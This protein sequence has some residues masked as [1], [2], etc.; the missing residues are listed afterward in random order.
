MISIHQQYEI[1]IS[2]EKICFWYI[3]LCN[4]LRY[5]L[6]PPQTSGL[7]KEIKCKL[8]LSHLGSNPCIFKLAGEYL[9]SRLPSMKQNTKEDLQFLAI[10][11]NQ[12]KDK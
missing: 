6:L 3:F 12:N 7:R 2:L 5:K 11:P 1:N 4:L 8:F 10:T 9:F